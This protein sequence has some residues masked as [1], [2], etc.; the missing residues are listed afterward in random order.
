MDEAMADGE[1]QSTVRVSNTGRLET[2]PLYH[3]LTLLQYSAL[4]AGRKHE[5]EPAV[6]GNTSRGASLDV[7]ANSLQVTQRHGKDVFN[8]LRCL[9]SPASF[10]VAPLLAFPRSC[11][12]CKE[13]H[14][15][16]SITSTHPAHL[17]RHTVRANRQTP[18]TSPTTRDPH[19][20]SPPT[21]HRR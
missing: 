2:V 4:A 20:S 21:N 15:T 3:P 6:T 14:F 13:D 11:C 9:R 17:T 10:T 7:T 12:L 5:T 19:P 8:K 18:A 1:V 16:F